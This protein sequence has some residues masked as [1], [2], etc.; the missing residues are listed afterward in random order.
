ML[1]TELGLAVTL[2]IGATLGI[3][4]F[5]ILIFWIQLFS[6]NFSS[7]SKCFWTLFWVHQIVWMVGVCVVPYDF[8]NDSFKAWA[9]PFMIYFFGSLAVMAIVKIFRKQ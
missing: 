9:W 5:A 6:K 7:E 4:G 2:L 8:L 1:V 3:V